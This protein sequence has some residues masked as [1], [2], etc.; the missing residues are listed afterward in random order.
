MLHR[1]AIL[2]F[3]GGV[4]ADPGLDN[5]QTNSPGSEPSTPPPDYV[6]CNSPMT[7]ISRSR[8]PVV[9]NIFDSAN[10]V[11]D[12]HFSCISFKIFTLIIAHSWIVPHWKL[13]PPQTFVSDQ[14]APRDRCKYPSCWK[15]LFVFSLVL[16]RKVCS[17][18]RIFRGK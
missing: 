3:L 8:A 14:I 10:D 9:G 12:T 16:C 13:L 11:Q 4:P 1:N 7:H 17:Q 6:P 18:G 5:L 15:V 2:S